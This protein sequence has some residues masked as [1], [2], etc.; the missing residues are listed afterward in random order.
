MRYRT[1]VSVAHFIYFSDF[2]WILDIDPLRFVQ[3]FPSQADAP[4]AQKFGIPNAHCILNL[5]YSLTVDQ[6]E[7]IK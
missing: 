5:A 7:D 4:W 6:L 1:K 3:N 2:N